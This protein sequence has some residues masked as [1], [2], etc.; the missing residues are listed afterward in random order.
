MLNRIGNRLS[1]LSTRGAI[2][3]ALLV[4]VVGSGVAFLLTRGGTDAQADTSVQPIAARIDQVDG[5]V[6]IARASAET[7]QLDWSEATVN[8]PVSIGDR[9]Y[10]RNGSHVSIALTGHDFVRLNPE[11]SLDVLAMADRRTQLA[12]RS[13]SAVFDVG[14][15]AS[16]EV[17][18][19]ATPC[20]AVNFTQPGLYQ[21]GLDGD[22]AVVSVLNG[23][24]RVI[25]VEGSGDINRGQVFTLACASP[26]QAVASP[27]ASDLA[28][29]IVDD[30]YRNRYTR[31]YD[32]R[33]RNYESYLGDPLFYDPYRTSPSYQYVSADI[34]GLND[35]DY[36]GDWVN[37]S[38]YGQCWAPRVSSGWAPFHSGYWDMDNLWGATW[39]ASEPW[40]WAPY[41]YGRWAYAS[42]RWFWVPDSGRTRSVYSPASVAFFSVAD[43]IAWVP[44]GPREVYVSRYYDVNYQPRY[45]ASADVINGVTRQRT[46]VNFNAPGAV[47][48]V[49]VNALTG[50]IG[51]GRFRTGDSNTIARSRA[52]LDPLSVDGVRQLAMNRAMN[53]EDAR[54]RI[55]LSRAEQSALS[56]PVVSSSK[57][58]AVAG[59][60]DVAKAFNVQAVPENR[61]GDKLKINQAGEATTMRRADGLP[62]TSLSSGAREQQMSALATRAEQGDKSARRE[63]RQ[64]MREDQRTGRQSSAQPPATGQ[65][66]QAGQSREQMKQQR[67]V[68]RQQQAA[69]AAQQ[70]GSRQPEQQQMKQQ[71]RAERQQQQAAPAPQQQAARQAQREQV[72][73]QRQQ[74]QAPQQVSPQQKPPKQRPPE[75]QQQ[76]AAMV[77]QQQAARAQQQSQRQ[78]MGQ[79]QAAQA[80]Q[81]QGQ[82]ARQTPRQG[83][84]LL[85]PPA[86]KG[87]AAKERGFA[88]TET[89][90]VETDDLRLQK[91]FVV[92]AFRRNSDGNCC[93]LRSRRN[94]RFRLKAGLRTF[95]SSLLDLVRLRSKRLIARIIT[96][97]GA[98]RQ[99]QQA[100]SGFNYASEV[101][102]RSDKAAA[103]IC[104]V[105]VTHLSHYFAR[106]SGAPARLAANY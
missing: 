31:V 50:A 21:V 17:Y 78:V 44:L 96:A 13:G 22:N 14:T 103:N 10:A 104:D 86:Q 77:Q 8:T 90:A 3:A 28:G 55:K 97:L 92:P 15:L 100:P 102:H 4:I 24:A 35:L 68:D 40:G 91:R 57:F 49:G 106:S 20:G 5:S 72:R 41:H 76:R 58:A 46:F 30:Y 42:D 87:S 1:S 79:Q 85:G 36:Y 62:Q 93:Y 82:A 84:V 73:Q 33:Y 95:L 19:V 38:D 99:I 26:S 52:L 70:A 61:K 71:R 9:I 101:V 89:S 63:M 16:D 48:V 67:R 69:P 105:R 27:I 6:G 53:R 39:V 59:R 29:N 47:T 25:G 83:P 34:P 7:E 81:S 94:S 45:L 11:A 54:H 88:A 56:T 23:V 75:V 98:N 65:Q 18:E 2:L 74:Q 80:Q 37:V 64:M 51:P 32:A 12:L 66:V 60:P 43:Q